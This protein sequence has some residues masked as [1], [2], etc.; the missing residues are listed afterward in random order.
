M[1]TACPIDAND[2]LQPA[3]AA[4]LEKRPACSAPDSACSPSSLHG[5]ESWIWAVELGSCSLQSAVLAPA[6]YAI[7][8]AT[9]N[10]SQ[11]TQSLSTRT[12]KI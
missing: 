10:K 2:L 9:L 3:I 6:S 8:S 5:Y 7:R 11:A 1:R 12:P 4:F